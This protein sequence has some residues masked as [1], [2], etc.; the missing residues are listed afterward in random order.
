MKF[1]ELSLTDLVTLRDEI[2]RAI[3]VADKTAYE[4]GQ[5]KNE[6]MRVSWLARAQKYRKAFDR[7]RR[8]IDTQVM[9]IIET[10]NT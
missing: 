6:D 9:N 2:G 10:G 3:V 7:V 4:M 1:D 8:E 5:K